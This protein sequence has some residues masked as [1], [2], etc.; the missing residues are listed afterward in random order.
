MSFSIG[1]KYRDKVW[2]DVVAMDACH[3]LLGKLWQYDGAAIHDGKNNT[4][5]LLPVFQ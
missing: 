4:S 2:F 5:V 1:T 3:L